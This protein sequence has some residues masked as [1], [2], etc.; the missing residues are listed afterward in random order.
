MSD[1]SRTILK[2]RVYIEQ[3]MEM[4]RC[5]FISEIID[6][7]DNNGVSNVGLDSRKRPYTVDAN[8]RSIE[9]IWGSIDPSDVP[10]VILSLWRDVCC[11]TFH[12]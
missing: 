4:D 3:S 11:S 12:Y 10:V 6:N 7:V 9:T 2:R 8:K 1:H 5:R